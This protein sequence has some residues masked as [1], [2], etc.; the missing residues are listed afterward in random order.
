M[1]FPE[2]ASGRSVTRDPCD[3]VPSP[4]ERIDAESVAPSDADLQPLLKPKQ[5][6]SLLAI[7][8]R[9]LW[10]WTN[11][12]DGSGIPHVRLGRC[13]RYHPNDLR[14]WIAQRRRGLSNG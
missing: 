4:C 12:R 13:I 3:G 7:S 11:L 1:H 6:A 10:Q 5:A 9:S 14:A 8:S 2:S